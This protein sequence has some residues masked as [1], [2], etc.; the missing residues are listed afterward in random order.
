MRITLLVLVLSVIP[1]YLLAQDSHYNISFFRIDKL[2]ELS[3]GQKTFAYQAIL[4][5]LR[6][7]AYE[8]TQAAGN[9]K[10]WSKQ[11]SGTYFILSF[12]KPSLIHF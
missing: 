7:T 9:E 4:S 1:G 3:E 11:A 5:T 2:V 12:D 10:E 8:S 6:A